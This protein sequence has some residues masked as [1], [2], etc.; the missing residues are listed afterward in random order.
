MFRD[1]TAPLLL[2]FLRFIFLFLERG[3]RKEKERER[4]TCEIN[5]HLLSFTHP[6]LG[7]WPTTQACALTGNRTSDLSICRPVLN[8][9]S[10]TSQGFLIFK[11][12][13]LLGKKHQ[14]K[15]LSALKYDLSFVEYYVAVKKLIK[16]T[17]E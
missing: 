13:L 14:S 2:F 7:T 15:Y 16:A 1:I 5:I 4:S 10:H 17:C 3:Q 12:L 8:P 11:P 6:Q 9:L